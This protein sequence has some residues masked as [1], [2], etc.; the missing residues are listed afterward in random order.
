MKEDKA[1]RLREW[2][3]YI[4]IWCLDEPL[5]M[6]FFSWPIF[7]V[8]IVSYLF[9]V[10]LFCSYN[11]MPLRELNSANSLIINTKHAHCNDLPDVNV[12]SERGSA[13]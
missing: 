13:C 10:F 9:F 2:G 12:T 5:T 3:E 11:G 8:N 1:I 6:S 7:R 4:A